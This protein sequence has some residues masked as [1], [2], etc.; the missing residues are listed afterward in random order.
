MI[1]S[2]DRTLSRAATVFVLLLLL[3]AAIGLRL[4]FLAEVDQLPTYVHLQSD[5]LAAHQAGV[6]CM[7]GRLPPH[8][9]LKAPVYMY[10]LGGLYTLAGSDPYVARLVQAVLC[11]LAVVVTYFLAR[12]L[13]GTVTAVVAGVITAVYWVFVTFS[14]ELV[15]ASLASLFYLLLAYLVAVGD[16]RKAW[17]WALAGA[18]MAIG[19]ITRPNVLICAPFLAVALFVMTYKR[20]RPELGGSQSGSR[21]WPR[22]RRAL[23]NTA[24]LT[25]G[26]CAV[27]APITIRNRVV[28]G[29]WVLIAAYGGLNLWVSNNPDSDGKNVAYIVGDATSKAAPIDPNDVWS[30]ALGDRV[31]RYYAEKVT[32]RSLARGELDSFYARLAWEYICDNPKKFL[33]DTLHRFVW[34]FNSY[35]FH[36]VRDPY[37]LTEHAPVLRVLSYFHFGILCPLMVMGVVAALLLR[38]R[39]PGLVYNVVLLATLAIGGVFFVVNARF[40]V[41]LIYLAVPFAA[42]ALVVLPKLVLG[43]MR[44]MHRFVLLGTLIAIVALSNT[45]FFGYRPKYH[46]DLC[47]AKA[48]ACWEARNRPLLAQAAPALQHAL[49]EDRATGN[50]T[51]ATLLTHARPNSL[52]FCSYLYLENLDK[53]LHYGRRMVLEEPLD[54]SLCEPFYRLILRM[55]P[56]RTYALLDELLTA[57]RQEAAR[58]LLQ[59]SLAQSPDARALAYSE[60]YVRAFGDPTFLIHVERVLLERL[61]ASPDSSQLTTLLDTLHTRMTSHGLPTRSRLGA[62]T[63]STKEQPGDG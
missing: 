3:G 28:G 15:D 61:D 9:F 52:L 58:L 55:G 33:I 38:E 60:R 24:A 4:A 35:E 11:S 48:A 5:E 51:W 30:D 22:M 45:D 32:G 62:T 12:A 56:E 6:A 31:A 49:A 21:R 44:L 29:E 34:L 39:S 40:R 27:I 50:R 20:Y 59:M 16:H 14:V 41:P 8:V 18:V 13:F 17:P 36:T 23:I 10:A 57:Q 47:F 26:C 42:Y 54:P 7:E 53:A 19:A 46:T 37:R 25:F 63:R 43:G 1:P 2:R